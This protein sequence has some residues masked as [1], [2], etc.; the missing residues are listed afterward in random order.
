M[1]SIRDRPLLPF[2]ESDQ[3]GPI[4]AQ[5]QSRGLG[6]HK[7]AADLRPLAPAALRSLLLI[8][9]AILLI[10]VL[11]PAAFVAAGT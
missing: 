9:L 5:H 2:G 6:L 1:T 3:P 7:V 8:A 11:L 10:L 4:P